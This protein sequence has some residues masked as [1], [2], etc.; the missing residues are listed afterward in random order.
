ML[1]LLQGLQKTIEG[2][3]IPLVMAVGG[4]L[5]FIVTLYVI[6]VVLHVK[7]RRELEKTRSEWRNALQNKPHDTSL[8]TSTNNRTFDTVYRDELVRELRSS[9]LPQNR[10]VE[11]YRAHRGYEKDTSQLSSK[12]WWKRAG[13][14]ARL[15]VIPDQTLKFGL[16]S[17]IYDESHEVRL[18]ALDYVAR[19]GK[20][21][22]VD[23]IKL[24]E[25][26]PPNLDSFLVIK[27]LST[28]PE[29][30][31]I[32]P[33][34][35]AQ[36]AR[37]RRCGATLL[38][39]PGKSEF[40]ATLKKLAGDDDPTTRKRTAEALGRTDEKESLE[41]L[42]K[43]AK[44]EIPSVRRATAGS[45]GKLPF[46]DALNLLESLSYDDHF[47][48]RLKAFESLTN[49]GEKGRRVVSDHFSEEPELAREALFESYQR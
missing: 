36:S 49:F 22:D 6:I 20:L 3:V 47:S 38:G 43:T 13:G 5:L 23:P 31:F 19:T 34:C 35:K 41:V 45:L 25:S 37:L 12:Y 28:E 42:E 27:L 32:N 40:L 1:K 14:L 33:L 8:D 15:K 39:Q 21:P 26:F 18:V 48:V 11:I 17:L 10:L 4:L 16:S 7:Q 29:L 44:D 30:D 24:F 2:F 9:D 46:D